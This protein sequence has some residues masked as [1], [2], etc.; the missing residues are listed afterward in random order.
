MYE[1]GP[2][3]SGFRCEPCDFES[4]HRN[5]FNKHM[6]TGKHFRNVEK[7]ANLPKASKKTTKEITQA[8]VV[9]TSCTCSF[10]KKDILTDDMLSHIAECPVILLK[11]QLDEKTKKIEELQKKSHK[12]VPD[13]EDLTEDD[14]MPSNKNNDSLNLNL[15]NASNNIINANFSNSAS[16]ERPKRKNLPKKTRVKAW[17]LN[18]GEEFG[19]GECFTCGC[20]IKQTDYECGHIISVKDGGSDNVDNLMPV[21]SQCNK[22]MGTMNM[23][24]FKAILQKQLK[25]KHD[26]KKLNSSHPSNTI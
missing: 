10:C 12:L 21:C 2:H 13:L 5:N 7:F 23:H 9:P 19:I 6:V 15:S 16:K 24:H 22:S 8:V 18:I 20:I 25:S 11:Q 26:K 14:Y 1:C 17:D 4:S 3:G